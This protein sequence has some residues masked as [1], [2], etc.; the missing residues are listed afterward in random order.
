MYEKGLENESGAFESLRR[1]KGGEVQAGTKEKTSNRKNNGVVDK[2]KAFVRNSIYDKFGK[3]FYAMCK[4][5]GVNADNEK[6]YWKQVMGVAHLA[7]LNGEQ[8]EM[9]FNGL[10]KQL[11]ENAKKEGVIFTKDLDSVLNEVLAD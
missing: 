11:E 6:A 4:S 2:K 10:E 5:A 1:Q 7:D 8:W 9:I 3:R